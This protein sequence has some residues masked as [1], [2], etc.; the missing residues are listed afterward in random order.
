MTAFQWQRCRVN[1]GIGFQK[2]LFSAE[3]SDFRWLGEAA[4]LF[5]QNFKGMNLDQPFS[6]WF[7][8]NVNITDSFGQPKLAEAFAGRVSPSLDYYLLIHLLVYKLTN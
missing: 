1:G 7:C 3:E 5:K 8:I 2:L 6:K 4:A